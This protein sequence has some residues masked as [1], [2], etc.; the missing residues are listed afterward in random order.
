MNNFIYEN[1][2]KLY[3]GVGILSSL[4]EELQKRAKK[5]LFLYGVN[6]IK[7]SGLY[8]EII[9]ILETYKIDYIEHSD[10]VPNPRLSHA[11]EGSQLCRDNGIELILAVGGGSVIDEAKGIAIGTYY[12]GDLWDIYSKKVSPE[13][14]LPIISVLTLPAT[15]SEMNGISVLVNDTTKEKWAI[16]YPV[17]IHPKVSF[18]EP[19]YTTTLSNEQVAIAT[20]D[21]MSHL[22]EGYFT[23]SADELYPQDELIEGVVRSIITVSKQ[24]QENPNDVSLRSSMM[25]CATL[26]W[27]GSLHAG[28]PDMNMPCH[29]LEMPMSGIYDIPHGAGLSIITPHWM[30]AVKNIYG[31]RI[32][33]LGKR[34]FNLENPTVETVA[35]KFEELY[36]T[37]GVATKLSE[38]GIEKLDVDA[39]CDDAYNSLRL[40]GIDVYTR[41]LVASIYESINNDS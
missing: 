33:R 30:R 23:T 4:G 6:S 27:N 28:I 21:I 38:V 39:C 15:G 16:N 10:V 32:I 36:H 11:V 1:P 22:T 5:V 37:I 25:R 7:K 19:T 3:S 9:T 24:I 29:A 40:R 35:M 12:D 26:G 34:V 14:A 20:A 13:K 8:D 41:E 18:L 31:K 2:T 17:L